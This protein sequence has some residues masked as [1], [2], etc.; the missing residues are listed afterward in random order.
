MNTKLTT[1][2]TLKHQYTNRPIRQDLTDDKS[3]NKELP[4]GFANNLFSLVARSE[5]SLIVKIITKLKE[6]NCL[7][8]IDPE[9]K[10]KNS[11]IKKAIK[12]LLIKNILNETDTK[13]FYIVN[14]YYIR[15]G[16]VRDTALYTSE[17]IYK[18]KGININILID[19]N[20]QQITYGYSTDKI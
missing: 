4:I 1:A 11:T 2:D 3:L 9:E 19:L 5:W 17:A 7:C 12:G 8:Y 16:N 10:A 14:P 15:R 18:N 20:P 6:Y 13:H